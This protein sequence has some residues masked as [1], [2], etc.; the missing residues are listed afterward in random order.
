MPT[1]TIASVG[2]VI[3]NNKKGFFF[4]F[5]RRVVVFFFLGFL[6][7]FVF[8]LA[9]RGFFCSDVLVLFYKGSVCAQSIYVLPALGR[10]KHAKRNSG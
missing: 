6:R 5:C 9:L 2:V 4:S 1:K 7:F 10:A 8:E 3:T